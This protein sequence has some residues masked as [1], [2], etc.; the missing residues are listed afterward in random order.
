MQ[1]GRRAAIACNGWTC[2]ALGCADCIGLPTVCLA[3]GLGAQGC[4]FLPTDGEP[5][6]RHAGLYRSGAGDST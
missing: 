1:R 6:Q 4:R 5:G 3:T 2:L